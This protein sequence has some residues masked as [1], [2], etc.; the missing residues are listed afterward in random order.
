MT[1]ARRSHP[2]GL[3]TMPVEQRPGPLLLHIQ[4]NLKALVDRSR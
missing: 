2:F 3:S 1:P 4:T